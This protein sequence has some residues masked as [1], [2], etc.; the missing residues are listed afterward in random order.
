MPK[1]IYCDE[2]GS[3]G[4]NLLD[5]AQPVFGYAAVS[6]D[7]E[8]AET[9]VAE[10]IARFRPQGDELKG[11]MLVGSSPGRKLVTAL[12]ENCG[13]DSIVSVWDKRFTLATQFFEHVFEPVLA[14]ENAIFYRIGFHKFVSNL[15]YVSFVA[16][17][18]RAVHAMHAFQR[19]VRARGEQELEQ[20]FP[21]ESALVAGADELLDIETFVRCHRETI[22]AYLDTRDEEDPIYRWSLDASLS[23]LWSLLMS[24][25]E[26]LD[27]DPLIV[28][29]DELKPL[30]EVRDRFEIM[31]GRRDRPL[32]EFPT[33]RHS[34]V[35]NLAEPLRFAKSH[36]EPGIQI[37]DVVVAAAVH[38]TKNPGATYS[39]E[40]LELLGNGVQRIFA[41]V[42]QIDL[43][44]PTGA[45]NAIVLKELVR[46]SILK[47]NLFHGM[48]EFI[49]TAYL[50]F[51]G[52]QRGLEDSG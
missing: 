25:S 11:R 37:A 50:T 27:P 44:A 7:P 43:T 36:D 6:L 35:F 32:V 39:Q 20:I 29:C 26:R 22:A 30:Y 42:D 17:T 40:W 51:L 21:V 48:P 9:L 13:K 23:A 18:P 15:L 3:T 52:F 1:H 45:V 2:T 31:I 10:L 14:E 28:T 24:W 34:P 5:V 41:E 47:K 46:R 8:R 33:G 19:V 4:S 12:L 16:S 38:A 49:R